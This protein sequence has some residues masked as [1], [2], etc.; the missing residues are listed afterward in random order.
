M[1]K[2][3]KKDYEKRYGNTGHFHPLLV[4]N[5]RKEMASMK[6]WIA[7][8]NN[9]IDTEIGTMRDIPQKAGYI[10]EEVHTETYNL[11]AIYKGDEGR[12]LTDRYDE[13]G[14]SKWQGRNLGHNDV[15]DI[16][17]KRDG[18]VSHTSQAKYGKSAEETARVMSRANEGEDAYYKDM[19]SM[20]GPS[21]QINPSTKTIPSE[22]EPVR[23]T[24]VEEHAKAKMEALESQGADKSKIEGYRN[25]A[26]KCTDRIR[27]GKAES[28]PLSKREAEDIASGNKDWLEKVESEYQTKSTIKQMGKAALGA[29]V[30]SGIMG[31]VKSTVNH[32]QLAKEGRITTEEAVERIVKDTV[33]AAADSAVKSSANACIQSLMT[34]YG[35]YEAAL[36]VLRDQGMKSMFRSC[37][38]TA[39]VT[40]AVDAI[41]DLVLFGTG[42]ITKKEFYDRQGKGM[43]MT[44]AGAAGGGAGAAAAASVGA[45]LG[46]GEG[47]ALSAIQ[48]AGGLSGGLIAGMATNLIIQN[49]V[50]KPYEDLIRNTRSLQYAAEDLHAVS[51]EFSWGQTLFTRSIE[52]HA[53]FANQFSNTLAEIDDTGERIRARNKRLDEMISQS[54]AAKMETREA[55]QNAWKAV[56]SVWTVNSDDDI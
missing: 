32:I 29:G 49:M 18:R 11:D 23:T 10:A 12:A 46:L 19:D 24:T 37:A 7:K 20:L 56:K 25:T 50:E 47:L 39:G 52:A 53:Q 16:V 35:S 27:D 33:C 31:G 15:P 2:R 26:E 34:R 38:V 36:E 13:W 8:A 28:R 44:S 30:M 55:I 21:D 51:G 42:R 41:K 17:V 6:E 43:L 3:D 5:A 54:S 14:D 45:A 22:Q 9:N 4:E 40:C 48:I 1:R